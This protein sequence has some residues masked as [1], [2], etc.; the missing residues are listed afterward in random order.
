MIDMCVFCDK[1]EKSRI[2]LETVE[3][4][5]FYDLFPVSKGHTL[6]PKA[7]LCAPQARL[8]PERME[9]AYEKSIPVPFPLP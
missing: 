4:I 3:W 7:A 2:V 5:A 6:R 9:N 8:A 1:I